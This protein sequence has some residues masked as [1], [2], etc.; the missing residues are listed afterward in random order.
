MIKFIKSE[1]K[2]RQLLVFFE[3]S[4]YAFLI[5]VVI[6]LFPSISLSQADLGGSNNES[7]SK[8]NPGNGIQK[9]PNGSITDNEEKLNAI[10]EILISEALKTKAKVKASSWI[11]TDGSLHE[12]LYVLSEGYS[13]KHNSLRNNIDKEDFN[14]N[15][16]KPHRKSKYCRFSN[17]SYARVAELFVSVGRSSLELPF[18]DLE[19]IREK[20]E[21]TYKVGVTTHQNW[22]FVQQKPFYK[23][24]YERFLSDSSLNKPQ[25]RIE[26]HVQPIEKFSFQKKRNHVEV[27]LSL[28]ISDLDKKELVLSSEGFLPSPWADPPPETPRSGIAQIAYAI[29]EANQIGKFKTN[30]QKAFSA[31]F[32]KKFSE[33]LSD[34]IKDT[35]VAFDC[36]Q[37]SFPISEIVNDTIYIDAG[38][39]RGIKLGDQLLLTDSDMIPHRILE[40]SAIEKIALVEIKSVTPYKAE[41][42]KIA[43]PDLGPVSKKGRTNIEVTPF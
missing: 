17:P 7:S 15:Q 2:I 18:N 42:R 30:T 19:T 22:V 31:H 37:I 27:K 34:I 9:K 38:Y 4:L 26:I 25:Y 24:S 40:E 33:G 11:D 13:T 41:A 32:E 23:T 8:D 29:H 5:S 1:E 20:A 14:I 16:L 28:K 36:R 21:K 43:G 39:E 6:G 3:R 10:R 12:N 35:I